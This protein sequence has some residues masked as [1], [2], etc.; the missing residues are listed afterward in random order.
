MP[1]RRLFLALPVVFTS[2]CVA[3]F[4]VPPDAIVICTEDA[5]CATGY[6]CSP[7]LSRCIPIGTSDAPPVIGDV[8]VTPSRVGHERVLQVSFTIDVPLAETPTVTLD[9]ASAT[10]PMTAGPAEGGYRFTYTAHRE[11]DAEGF[12]GV[13][14]SVIGENG[15]R[16]AASYPRIA[17]LDFEPPSIAADTVLAEISASPESLLPAVGAIGLG[18]SVTLRFLVSEPLAQTPEITL[19]SQPPIVL[20]CDPPLGL[21]HACH[22][23][24]LPSDGAHTFQAVLVD[25]AGNEALATMTQEG[26]DGGVPAPLIVSADGLRPPAAN[27]EAPATLV[28]VRVPWGDHLGAERRLELVGAAGAVEGGATV[29][30]FDAPDPSDRRELGRTLAGADGAFSLTLDGA[31]RARVYV[32][33]SDAAGNGS[34]PLDADGASVALLVRHVRW[35]AGLAGKRSGSTLENPHTLRQVKSALPAAP[36]DHRALESPTEGQQAAA[37]VDGVRTS[38]STER[39]FLA[40]EGPPTQSLASTLVAMPALGGFLYASN[41]GGGAAAKLWMY[42]DGILSPISTG[43]ETLFLS[44]SQ[45][46]AY[47]DARNRVVLVGAEGN[48]STTLAV[49]EWDGASFS[50]PRPATEPPLR[51]IFG[52]THDR[53]R[54][55]TVLY[56]G[57]AEPQSGSCPDG[58][59]LAGDWCIFHD[60]WEWD[61]TTWH[62]RTPSGAPA[63]GPTGRTHHAFAYDD[64]SGSTI[65][66]GGCA[67]LFNCGTLEPIFDDVWTWDGLAWQGRGVSPAGPRVGHAAVFD[68]RVSRWI[69]HGGRGNGGAVIDDAWLVSLDDSVPWQ[70]LTPTPPRPGFYMFQSITYDSARERLLVRIGDVVS[71][72]SAPDQCGRVWQLDANGWALLS[73]S[74]LTARAYSPMVWDR[75][76][77]RLVRFGGCANPNAV[78]SSVSSGDNDE[79]WEWTGSA[80]ERRCETAISDECPSMPGARHGHALAYNSREK[81]VYLFGGRNMNAGGMYNDLW[82]WSGSGWEEVCG[83]ACSDKPSVRWGH[84]MVYDASR[85]RLVMF[86][87]LSSPAACTGGTYENQ[88]NDVWEWGPFGTAACGGPDSCWK[89]RTVSGTP[90]APRQNHALAYDTIGERVLMFGGELIHAIEADC[91]TE[92][93][94]MPSDDVCLFGALWQLDATGWSKI[95][96]SSLGMTGFPAP[97]HRPQ[98]FFDERRRL[99]I[100]AGGERLPGTRLQDLWQWNGDAWGEVSVTGSNPLATNGFALAYD[101]KYSR[102]VGHGGDPTNAITH[103]SWLWDASPDLMPAWLFDVG[104]ASAGEPEAIPLSVRVEVSASGRGYSVDLDPAGG[105]TGTAIDGVA[106]AG[107]D[108]VSGQFAPLATTETQTLSF[109]TSSASDAARLLTQPEQ[110]VHLRIAPAAGGGNGPEEASIALDAVSATIDYDIP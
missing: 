58:S 95:G 93:E 33:V 40:L 63:G 20:D 92:G 102:L 76:R 106:L 32:A 51:I 56:G 67:A 3:R 75:A 5:E 43:E 80:W 100:L 81:A 86:G 85:D 11:T 91:G 19:G 60:V 9:S 4:N 24:V 37:H 89:Q 83:A 16:A 69:V 108:R 107:W 71:C 15:I 55:V 21:S 39:R 8:S 13:S 57:L 2:H 30:A 6:R 46:G 105:F 59:T 84:A 44:A 50:R 82:R 97:R 77:D 36:W 42:Y 38:L 103:T 41:S 1:Y 23:E 109:V 14:I 35:T 31:D 99:L 65:L 78:C 27:V 34:E 18:G 48:A 79:T 53:D 88:C 28:L 74:A 26:P 12:V 90:P 73:A 54:G 87:G 110:R 29:V 101:Q 10:H 72:A 61:G 68:A 70:S 7:G 104:F 49:W 47:D 22:T 64:A 96:P 17:E 94:F 98:L 62:N 66:Y 25:T 52:L 45:A